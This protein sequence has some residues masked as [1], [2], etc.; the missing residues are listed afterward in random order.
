[1]PV[2]ATEDTS[3]LDLLKRERGAFRSLDNQSAVRTRKLANQLTGSLPRF[4]FLVFVLLFASLAPFPRPSHPT[5][6]LN[7]VVNL[8]VFD[9]SARWI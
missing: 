1:M 7:A 2:Y 3:C 9:K 4:G 5:L 6:L 8:Q